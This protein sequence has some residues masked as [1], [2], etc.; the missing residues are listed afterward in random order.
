MS[1]ASDIIRKLMDAVANEEG[2]IPLIDD[3][4][5]TKDG[6]TFQRLDEGR[7]LSG[8]FDRNIRIDQ[9]THVAGNGKVHAHV[10]G[11]KGNQI[12]VVNIDGTGSHGSKGILHSKDAEALRAQGFTIRDDRIVEW[13]VLPD[14]GLE[15]LLG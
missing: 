14:V 10:L 9:P 6:S 15:L 8:R 11:R 1:R 5:V 2:G 3:V 7:F 12:V 4:T 13:T